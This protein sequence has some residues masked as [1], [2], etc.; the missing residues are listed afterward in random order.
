MG[1]NF[2]D[3]REGKEAAVIFERCLKEFPRSDHRDRYTT[4]LAR[5][6]QMQ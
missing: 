1:L 3:L 4:E 2:I 6:R 5:A